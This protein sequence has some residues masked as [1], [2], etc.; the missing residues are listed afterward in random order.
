MRNVLIFLLLIVMS[1]LVIDYY[2]LSKFFCSTYCIV[3]IDDILLGLLIVTLISL[4]F[5]ISLVF[6]PKK[7]FICW[8]S[9]ARI[10][11]PIIFLISFQ[12]N[13]KSMNGGGWF[14]ISDQIDLI[15]M[16]ILYV[17][18]ILGSLIQIYRGY[19]L[20]KTSLK[21]VK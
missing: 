18:F 13:L 17:V 10:A 2:N 16:S 4:L 12:I 1:L 19:E 6:L 5:I 8:W 9:F 7:C 15:E 11:I 3:K 20:D 21:K 14:S